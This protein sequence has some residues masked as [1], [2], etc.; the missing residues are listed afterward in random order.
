MIGNNRYIIFSLALLCLAIPTLAQTQALDKIE[1]SLA[2]KGYAPFVLGGKN[3][4]KCQSFSF[5]NPELGS[6]FYPIFS[7]N[8]KLEPTHQG[9]GRVGVRLNG[10]EIAAEQSN[11][12]ACSTDT[13]C[14]LRVWAQPEQ[15]QE[16][17]TLQVCLQNSD[18]VTKTTLENTSLVG[19]Y[20]AAI[21]TSKDFKQSTEKGEYFVNEDIPFTIRVH[22]SGTQDAAVDVNFARPV[23]EEL[24]HSLTV[25]GDT[26]YGNITVPA[27]QDKTFTYVARIDSEQDLIGFVPASLRYTDLFGEVHE[28]LSNYILLE[29]HENLEAKAGILVDNAVLPVNGSTAVKIVVKNNSTQPLFDVR[30]NL[31]AQPADLNLNRN[32]TVELSKLNVGEEREISFIATSNQIKSYALNCSL[33]HSGKQLTVCDPVVLSFR[34]DAT[35]LLLLQGIVLAV[36]A[37]LAFILLQRK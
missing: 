30:L 27:G 16:E 32:R 17:N 35:A 31:D 33:V 7:L 13:Q 8:L 19:F 14:L 23:A 9:T 20:K 29:I 12:L 1:T 5:L 15:L 26:Y 3:A 34:E 4:E 24:L 6:A 22:N 21:F 28:M 37:V 25:I 18:S 10:T 2:D 36:I 11:E